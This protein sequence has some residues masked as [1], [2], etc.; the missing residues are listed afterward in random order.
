MYDKFGHSQITVHSL[1]TV[2]LTPAAAERLF[3][4]AELIATSR[5]NRL[6]KNI[7]EKLLMLKQIGTNDYAYD[8]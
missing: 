8:D 3:S 6:S 4:R 1:R 7:L 5:R 2:H